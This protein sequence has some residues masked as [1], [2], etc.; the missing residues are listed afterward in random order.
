MKDCLKQN[1]EL[2]CLLD[3]LRA[4]QANMLHIKVGDVHLGTEREK[5]DGDKSGTEAYKAEF[6]SLKVCL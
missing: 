2:R 5:N 1:E 4:D 6:V 3:K